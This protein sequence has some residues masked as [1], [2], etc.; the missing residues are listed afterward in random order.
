MDT[1]K[2][3]LKTRARKYAENRGVDPSLIDWE[4]HLDTSLTDSENWNI[5]KEKVKEERDG[6]D[7]SEPEPQEPQEMPEEVKKGYEKHYEE[8]WKKHKE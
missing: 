3:L 2:P 6:V 8:K 1:N 4:A 5:I 7:F